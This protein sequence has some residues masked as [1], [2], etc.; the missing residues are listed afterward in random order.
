MKYIL[1]LLFIFWLSFVQAATLYPADE[2]PAPDHV[3]ATIKLR[4]T[5]NGSAITAY[6][7]GN[8]QNIGFT[9]AGDFD[10]TA[11][12][13]FRGSSVALVSVFY[14]QIGGNA[15]ACNP[16][17][18]AS[19]FCPSIWS[20]PLANSRAIVFPGESSSGAF[21][22]MVSSGISGDACTAKDYAII[23]VIQPSSSL[24]CTQA[25]C[26]GVGAG[27][28]FSLNSG[29]GSVA[30][31]L[32]NSNLIGGAAVA[33]GWQAT[34]DGSSFSFIASSSGFIETGPIVITVISDSTGVRIYQNER[35]WATASRSALVRTASVFYLGQLATSSA[36]ATNTAWGGGIAAAMLYCSTLPTQPQLA[37]I[38]QAL[39]S[40]YNISPFPSRTFTYQVS[41]YGDSIAAG[42]KPS[43]GLYGYFAYLQTLLTT[44][45]RLLNFGDPGSTITGASYASTN[46]MITQTCA[47]HGTQYAT[48]GRVAVIHGGGNDPL[49]G[50]TGLSGTLTSGSNVITMASTAGLSVGDY[51]YAGTGVPIALAIPTLSTISSINPNVS[52]T[53]SSN[54]A[55]TGTYTLTFTYAANSPAAVY[56]SVQG[57]VT[58]AKACGAGNVVVMTVLKRN[59]NYQPFIAALNALIVAGVA[60]PPSYT[61]ADCA[62]YSTLVT[63]PGANYSDDVHLSGLPNGAVIAAQCLQ[64]I[65]A[66]LTP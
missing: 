9:T 44:P 1:S 19:P 10:A 16:A 51:V 62:A 37:R 39:Y 57:I 65:I 58:A 20:Q 45:V 15:V 66:A 35:I 42:Y 32:N 52:I 13:T 14:D 7:S 28:V 63:N 12:D 25:G 24:F 31:L 38:R 18:I 59:A 22:G 60:G 21:A 36:G 46:N 55:L 49:L 11:L 64:P 30:Q 48:R 47:V 34:D 2:A 50:P 3:W 23:A 61:L 41:L 43:V 56:A 54:A 6:L 27:A 33:P 40:R 5:W 4:S 29:S 8:T 53:I 26:P 17:A